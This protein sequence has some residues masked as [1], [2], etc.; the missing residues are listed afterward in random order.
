MS[1]EKMIDQAGTTAD[2]QTLTTSRDSGGGVSEAYA[3]RLTAQPIRIRAKSG[4][5][6]VQLGAERVVSTHRMYFKIKDVDGNKTVVNE[7]DQIVVKDK[8]KVTLG[9][10]DVDFSDNPNELGQFIQVDATQR[11]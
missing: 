7:K 10:F 2:V 3:D 8:D 9:T 4:N 6:L 1:I 11:V 5:E